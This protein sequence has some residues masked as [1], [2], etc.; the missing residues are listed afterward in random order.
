MNTPNAIP[1]SKPA[2]QWFLRILGLL[3]AAGVLIRIVLALIHPLT[4]PD[5]LDYLHLAHSIERGAP[6]RVTGMYAKRLP[7]YPIFM[8]GVLM[9][10]GGHEMGILIWQAL[11]SGGLIYLAWRL[12]RQAGL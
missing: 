3:I 2:S 8:A 9:T 10:D 7:G 12:G 4:F 5:S 11:I 1:N 6:Y